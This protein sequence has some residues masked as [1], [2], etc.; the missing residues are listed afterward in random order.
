[1]LGKKLMDQRKSWATLFNS[2]TIAS[3][4]ADF[5]EFGLLRQLLPDFVDAWEV[6]HGPGQ[7]LGHTACE[8]KSMVR[9]FAHF[10][11]KPTS[12]HTHPHTC[13]HMQEREHGKA[14]YAHW[15]LSPCTLENC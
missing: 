6:V 3:L 10:A 4:C 14:T 1:M 8:T 9:R 7:E 5:L 11:L 12:P 15:P 2:H 13:M